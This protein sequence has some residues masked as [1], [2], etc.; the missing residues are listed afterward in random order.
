MRSTCAWF[1]F[2]LGRETFYFIWIYEQSRCYQ[3]L[4]WRGK[5][6]VVNTIMSLSDVNIIHSW[7][8]WSV[9]CKLPRVESSTPNNTHIVNRNVQCMRCNEKQEITFNHPYLA[10]KERLSLAMVPAFLVSMHDERYP[11]LLSST[12]QCS[13]N[14]KP[15]WTQVDMTWR[16]MSKRHSNG[17]P[18]PWHG[19]AH[20]RLQSL[21]Y[22]WGFPL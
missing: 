2:L 13:N 15:I 1:T 20:R 10:D 4:R 3:R 17:H 19:L 6:H 12:S 16:E 9:T 5:I 22:I 7:I 11:A 14:V 18:L 8:A 21:L